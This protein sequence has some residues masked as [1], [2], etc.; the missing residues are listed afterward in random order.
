MAALLNSRL[1]NVYYKVESGE[2]ARAFP[3]VHIAR[4]KRLPVAR[5]LIL[6]GGR[7]DALARKRLH[8]SNE[9][10]AAQLDDQINALVGDAYGVAIQDVA[11]AEAQ[12]RAA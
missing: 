2:N 11:A 8:N 12:L 1:L 9:R 7:L 5:E 3:Q 10:L 4:L 6:P